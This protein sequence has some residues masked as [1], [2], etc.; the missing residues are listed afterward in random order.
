MRLWVLPFLLLLPLG[1]TLAGCGNRA[2]REGVTDIGK[3][4]S[5][6]DEPSP[7]EEAGVD[8]EAGLTP[9]SPSGAA[10]PDAG[11]DTEAVAP[12]TPADDAP[13]DAAAETES[14]VGPGAPADD[15]Q[16][17]ATAVPDS[18]PGTAPADA[19]AEAG[20]SA[21]SPLDVTPADAAS[22]PLTDA[23]PRPGTRPGC[24]GPGSRFVTT[25]IAHRFGSGQT[26][27]QDGFPANVFGPPLG[28]G[29]CSGSLDV[30]SLG[31]GGTVTVAFSG[32]VVVDGPG[33]DFLVFE[34]AFDLGGVATKPYAELGMVEVSQDGVSWLAFPCTATAFPYGTCAGW[35]PVFAN[36]TENMI[37][38]TD[39]ATAGGDPF[40]LSDV[41]LD[42]AQFVRVTD[43]PGDGLSFDLD[44][45]AIVNGGCP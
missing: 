20:V 18:S 16:L 21:T 25:I 23:D 31:D 17:D 12:G 3:N 44:A 5:G 30:A 36:A 2:N 34:N 42:W 40:D 33:P 4:D 39:P 41:G 28:G 27:G 26:F 29:C 14:P 32:N 9:E 45:M 1:A 10:S 19:A 35:H 24:D 15:N 13:P 37:D 22:P 8:V 38:P 7:L 6:M 43:R 11:T